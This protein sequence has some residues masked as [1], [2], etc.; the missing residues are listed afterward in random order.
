MAVHEMGS[1]DITAHQH[2]W[3]GFTK[4]MTYCTVSLVVTTLILMFIFG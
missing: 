3:K 1:M 4:L 2:V